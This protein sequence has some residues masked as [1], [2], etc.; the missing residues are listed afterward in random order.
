MALVGNL[1]HIS[2]EF[3]RHNDS[4][5]TNDQPIDY[6]KHIKTIWEFPYVP[7]FDFCIQLITFCNSWSVSFAVTISSLLIALEMLFSITKF[8]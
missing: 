1:Y 8:T 5:S 6:S 7:V 2:P 4:F 3:L